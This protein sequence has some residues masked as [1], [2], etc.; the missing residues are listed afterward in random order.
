VP[1]DYFPTLFNFYHEMAK[2]TAVEY[3]I[4]GHIGENHLHFNFFPKNDE[5]KERAS[6]AYIEAV[7]RAVNAG[8]TVSAE[9]GIGKLKHKYLEMMYGREGIMEMVRIK[10]QIDP[11]CL[12]GLNN[13]FPKELLQS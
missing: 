3:V 11:F 8:G 9:H 7:K 13:I 6:I 12:L 4:F 10:K 2:T 1:E 5:E